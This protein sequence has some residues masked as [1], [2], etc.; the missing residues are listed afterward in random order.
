MEPVLEYAFVLER[1]AP[2]VCRFRLAGRHLNDLMGQE[3]RGMPA[4]AMFEPESRKDISRLLEKVCTTAC[5]VDVSL[6]AQAGFGRGA[7]QARLFLAPL[8]D[9]QGRVTRV[10][11]CL[12]S[13]G[14]IG[15]Q[16]RRFSVTQ[17][18]TKP[19]D[20]SVIRLALPIAIPQS[21][22]AETAPSFEH[23]PKE[24]HEIPATGLKLVVDNS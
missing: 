12:Q 17:A 24:A 11:G 13:Q 3:V 21:A 20:Y 1:L 23:Q 18:T 8:C 19:T 10:L 9:D 7:L 15:R 16:P 4:T 14:T 22:F 5:L 2:G 6:S